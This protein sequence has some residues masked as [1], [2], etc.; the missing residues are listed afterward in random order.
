VFI[1]NDQRYGPFIEAIPSSLCCVW[2]YHPMFL[3]RH[4][5]MAAAP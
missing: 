2:K 3:L 5:R 1:V 4:R